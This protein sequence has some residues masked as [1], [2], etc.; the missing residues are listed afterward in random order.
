MHPFLLATDRRARPA[1]LSDPRRESRKK[2]RGEVYHGSSEEVGMVSSIANNV[3]QSMAR[4]FIWQYLRDILVGGIWT[5]VN[6]GVA[7][8]GF[9]LLFYPHPPALPIGLTPLRIL[10]AAVISATVQGYWRVWSRTLAS[11]GDR[12]LSDADLTVTR[13]EYEDWDAE[14]GYLA[15]K[16]LGLQCVAGPN[17]VA[18]CRFRVEDLLVSTDGG[19]NWYSQPG[20]AP[21][22]LEWNVGGVSYTLLAGATRIAQLVSFSRDS[23]SVS[24]RLPTGKRRVLTF[25]GIWR[26]EISI[27][28]RGYRVRKLA[29]EFA[30]GASERPAPLTWAEVRDLTL[31]QLQPRIA[32]PSPSFRH[33]QSAESRAISSQDET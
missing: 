11:T 2:R 31:R 15:G 12:E 33:V 20:F 4:R 32:P 17:E 21:S 8:V 24:F 16:V 19:S 27:E 3:W 18:D 1:E 7:V 29:V 30:W 9:L 22:E 13:F 26:V 10:G 23:G 6:V 25:P 14:T 5:V 28:A